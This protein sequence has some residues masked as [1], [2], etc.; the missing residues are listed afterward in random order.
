MKIKTQIQVYEGL[1]GFTLV[2]TGYAFASH[3]WIGLIYL[4]VSFYFY[5][6][7]N[8]L[9]KIYKQEQEWGNYE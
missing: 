4:A 3:I 2:S 5:Y 6:M 1:L 7:V 9:E 8:Y